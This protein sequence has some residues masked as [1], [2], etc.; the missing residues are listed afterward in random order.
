VS[1]PNKGKL[2]PAETQPQPAPGEKLPV[3]DPSK[4]PV[5]DPAKL[6]VDDK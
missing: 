6:P 3:D 2:K 1:D 4:L 5:T